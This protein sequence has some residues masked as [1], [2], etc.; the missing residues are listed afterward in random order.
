MIMAL[1]KSQLAGGTSGKTDDYLLLTVQFVGLN[2]I[3][4]A[5]CAAYGFYL[6][7]LVF[8]LLIL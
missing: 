1:W 4:S 6:M 8:E 2:T 5:Y 3:F 7:A